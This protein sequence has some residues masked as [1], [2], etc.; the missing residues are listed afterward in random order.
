MLPKYRISTHVCLFLFIISYCCG[1]FGIQEDEY[2]FCQLQGRIDDC[3]CNVD[4]VDHFNNVKVYPRLRSLLTKN[5]FRFYKV[6]LK[7]DCPFWTDDSRCAMKYCH[8]EACQEED[9]P[10]GLKGGA[11]SPKLMADHGAEKYSESANCNDDYNDELGYLNTTISAKAEE[12]FALWTAHDAQDNF[13]D[14]NENDSDA[15]YVD[16]LL[17]PERYTGYRGKSAHRIWHS[18]Y[19]ENC[20]RPQNSYSSYIH[21]DL[22]NGM[23]LEKRAFYRAI[24]GLHA[25]INIHLCAK[26]L[27]SESSGI[28]LTSPKGEWGPNLEEFKSRFSPDNTI[29]EGPNWLRNLYFLYLLE[30]RALAKASPYL[31]REEFY[32]GDE[33]QDWDTQLAVKD[34]LSVIKKFPDHFN[35]SIMFS[36]GTEANKMKYEFKQHFRNITRIMDCVGCDKCKLWGKLQ[37]QGLGTALKILFSGKF[38]QEYTAPYLQNKHKKDFQLER[39]EIVSLINSIGRLSTS[40]YEL[41]EFRLMLR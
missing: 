34:L 8:V 27:L 25:S 38:D 9:I 39:T 13:C 18:I 35:E 22:L 29:G 21:S 24:S 15:E 6:N 26:Y 41:D 28:S 11:K 19:M 37:I 36:G 31:Q 3:S 4:T 32:T 33:A 7:H 17:N 16:L 23:C 10:P 1:Y 14:V 30:I 40:I 2:C 20:F 12:D 5:Y